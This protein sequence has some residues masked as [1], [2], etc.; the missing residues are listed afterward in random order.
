MIL[1]II[2]SFVIFIGEIAGI[3][4]LVKG[5]ALTPSRLPF[6]ASLNS[7]SMKNNS[8]Y[9]RIY[10]RW[11][12]IKRRC[13][14]PSRSD[15]KGYGGRGIKVYEP[16][17]N[18]FDSFHKYIMS[19]P[20]AMLQGLTIDRIENDGNY[21]PGNLRWA[22]IQTQN[23]NTRTRKD[24][25]VKLTG[26][27]LKRGKYESRITS[28]SKYIYLGFFDTVNEALDVRN[29]YIVNNNLQNKIQ[30]LELIKP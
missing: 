17:I 18:D 2:I 29:L 27:S 3:D 30:H 19:L 23:L 21:E 22:T 1:T 25:K 7:A 28:K 4:P 16:W 10:Q 9:Q 12:D 8:E 5:D 14:N 11:Y 26:I 20:M 24:N 13:Y 6:S 15:F